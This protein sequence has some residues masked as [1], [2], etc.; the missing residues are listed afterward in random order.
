LDYK[1]TKILGLPVHVKPVGIITLGYPAEKL[2]RIERIDM[3]KLIH[4]ERYDRTI[5]VA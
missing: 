3:H 2:E 5:Q 1:V 4:Y